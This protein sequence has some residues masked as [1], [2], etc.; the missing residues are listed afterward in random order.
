MVALRRIL[1][2]ILMVAVALGLYMLIGTGITEALRAKLAHFF[3]KEFA[4]FGR[5]GNR[6]GEGS[7]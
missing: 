4:E 6:E 2:I 7:E 1:W 3:K 5:K